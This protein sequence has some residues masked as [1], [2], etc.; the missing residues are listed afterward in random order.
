LVRFRFGIIVVDG[1]QAGVL[2]GEEHRGPFGDRGQTL[3]FAGGDEAAPAHGGVDEGANIA[4]ARQLIDH[5][6]Q[7]QTG[8]WTNRSSPRSALNDD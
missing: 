8:L 2:P 4:A 1:A 7:T 6:R 5:R 3:S